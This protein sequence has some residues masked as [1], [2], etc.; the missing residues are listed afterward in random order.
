MNEY[1]VRAIGGQC[2]EAEPNGF[3]AR[4]A[5]GDRCHHSQ[6]GDAAIVPRS[7]LGPDRDQHICDSPV[8]AEGSNSMA[9]DGGPAERQVLFGKWAAKSAAL[10]RRDNERVNRRH[11]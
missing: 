5:A 8:L 9:Q 10:A 2:F 6:A 4:R 1:T 3:L 7:V 11:G